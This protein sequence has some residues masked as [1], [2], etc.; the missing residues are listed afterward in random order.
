[1]RKET[2]QDKT[3][4]GVGTSVTVKFGEIDENIRD[5]ER[6]RI[7]KEMVGFYYLEQ[8][9]SDLVIS[10]FW[11]LVPVFSMVYIR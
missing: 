10:Q 2:K 1:M 6:R 3:K 8:I 9:A 4:I 7:S 11:W 5:G